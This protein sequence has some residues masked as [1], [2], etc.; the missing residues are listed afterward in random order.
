MGSLNLCRL[1]VFQPSGEQQN[2]A[3]HRGN[4]DV[5]DLI[6][7]LQLEE[8]APARIR[9]SGRS[10]GKQMAHLL[11]GFRAMMPEVL[12]IRLLIQPQNHAPSLSVAS[13]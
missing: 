13:S 6:A 3:V 2:L 11:N 9:F 7:I 5:K 12:D 4:V 1:F 10:G 8:V